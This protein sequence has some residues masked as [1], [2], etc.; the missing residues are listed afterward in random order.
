[1]LTKKKKK[2]NDNCSLVTSLTESSVVTGV[3]G[4]P[5]QP[6][7]FR[8]L[9]VVSKPLGNIGDIAAN[10]WGLACQNFYTSKNYSC[11]LGMSLQ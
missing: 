9:L 6:Q 10:I 5:K 1:M 4:L 11:A 2:R 7:S 8:S 3:V